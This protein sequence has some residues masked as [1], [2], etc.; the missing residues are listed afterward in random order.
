MSPKSITIIVAAVVAV[1]LAA[2]A[3]AQVDCADWNTGA[4]F[5][6]ADVSDVTRCLLAGADPN[7][8]AEDGYTP[9]HRA[10]EFGTAEAV[11]ALLEGGGRI[12]R[13]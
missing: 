3:H 9:L 10:A 2:P 5:E 12:W 13:R 1:A 6:A 8:G 11:T 7:A 4:F